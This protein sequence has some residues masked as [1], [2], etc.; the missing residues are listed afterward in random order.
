M[1]F[2]ALIK[3]MWLRGFG[4]LFTMALDGMKPLLGYVYLGQCLWGAQVSYP[5]LDAI[6]CDWSDLVI[7]TR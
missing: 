6:P 1:Q 2:M 4:M 7:W 3:N 5:C